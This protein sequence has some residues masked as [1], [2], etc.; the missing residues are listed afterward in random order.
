[1]VLTLCLLV[2]CGSNSGSGEDEKEDTETVE[3]TEGLLISNSDFKVSSSSNGAYS[4]YPSGTKG[5]TGASMY[6]SGK[7]PTGVI[8][9]V[10]SI[11]NGKESRKI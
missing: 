7:F 3:A 2:A 10:I 1:M 6:S 8:A 11:E 9:G 5:W 4:T